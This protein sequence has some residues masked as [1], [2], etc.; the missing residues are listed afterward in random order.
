MERALELKMT[1]VSADGY[2]VYRL[3]GDCDLY[4][5]PGFMREM[6]A[7][8]AGGLSSIRFDCTELRYLDSTGVGAIVKILQA[9]RSAKAE[10]R[11]YGLSGTPRRVLQLCNIL[12]IIK[13]D[14]KEASV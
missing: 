1:G 9:A 4:N 5:A 11:F 2:T 10:I 3:R 14:P 8:L 6:V 7:A 13:E 12:S